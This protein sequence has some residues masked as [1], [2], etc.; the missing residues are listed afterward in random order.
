MKIRERNLEYVRLDLNELPEPIIDDNGW[1]HS[2]ENV[3]INRYDSDL[4]DRLMDKIAG[5]FRLNKENLLL[6]AGADGA[7]SLVFNYCARKNM[8]LF[9][10]EPSYTGFRFIAD[11]N[12]CVSVGYPTVDRKLRQVPPDMCAAANK[13]A[14]VFCN[15][16]NPTGYMIDDFE[17]FVRNP[18]N[19]VIVDEAYVE[20]EPGISAMKYVRE[21]YEN[22]IV[23]RTFSKAFGAASI[24]LGYIAAHPD[25]IKKLNEYQLRYPVSSLAIEMGLELWEQRSRMEENVAE[26]RRS[27]SRLQERFTQI[28]LNVIPSRMNFFSFTL[29][30]HLPLK[31]FIVR[32]QM[33]YVYLRPFDFFNDYGPLIRV[34]AGTPDENEKL[35]QVLE[36]FAGWGDSNNYQQR[37][38]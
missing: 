15:P 37:R 5:H 27:C 9:L 13:S 17:P 19:L 25:L 6:E 4:A 26:L 32:L 22:I 7:L 34:T 3:E 21:G 18:E 31:D 24:R 36:S 16:D 2:Q 23:I 38:N 28:G 20:F 10:P 29:P 1:R 33:H 30:P 12:R 8:P 14:L 11:V 35:V